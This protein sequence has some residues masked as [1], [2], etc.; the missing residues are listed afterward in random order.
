VAFLCFS[1][2]SVVANYTVVLK[3]DKF[4]E[5][6][7]ATFEF[8][9]NRPTNASIEINGTTYSVNNTAK[10]QQLQDQREIVFAL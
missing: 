3:P 6:R 9:R 7:N 5:N 2:G 10:D 1:E 4:L 8:I